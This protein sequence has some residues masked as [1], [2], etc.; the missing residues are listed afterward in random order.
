MYNVNQLQAYLQYHAFISANGI[1]LFEDNKFVDMVNLV[2]RVRLH[3]EVMRWINMG[4]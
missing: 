3:I 1:I 4:S 2:E